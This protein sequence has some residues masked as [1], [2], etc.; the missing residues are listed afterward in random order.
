MA[1]A[2]QPGRLTLS[3]AATAAC[4]PSGSREDER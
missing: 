1:D 4:V 2:G 3:P